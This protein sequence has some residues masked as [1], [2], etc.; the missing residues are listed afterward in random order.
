MYPLCRLKAEQESA[1]VNVQTSGEP[2]S[3][4]P[5]YEIVSTEKYNERT[6]DTEMELEENAAYGYFET[7][8]D[9]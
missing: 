8:R 6:P 4:N 5:V 3:R 1:I 9:I 7:A 2:S